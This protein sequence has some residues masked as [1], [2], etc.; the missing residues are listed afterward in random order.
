MRGFKPNL[1]NAAVRLETLRTPEGAALPDNTLA[2]LR[3]ELTRLQLIASQIREI[4]G[5]RL[6]GCSLNRGR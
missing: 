4:E 3:R 2:E 1:R 5:A 6:A